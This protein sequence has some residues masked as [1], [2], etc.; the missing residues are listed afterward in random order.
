LR[1]VADEATILL[2]VSTTTLVVGNGFIQA[3]E[4]MSN[5]LT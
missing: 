3:P 2:L 5:V 1:I 4:W